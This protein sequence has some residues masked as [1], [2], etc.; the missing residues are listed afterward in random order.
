MISKIVEYS[1]IVAIDT[2]QIHCGES[3]KN[4]HKIDEIT[5]TI[6]LDQEEYELFGIIEH[7]TSPQ[8]F[9]PHIKRK[10]NKWLTYDDIVGRQ[11][12]CS[13][14]NPIAIQMIFYKKKNIGTQINIKHFFEFFIHYLTK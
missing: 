7:Q 10:S 3:E 9:V 14:E 11:F 1:P 2:E 12:E 6:R 4:L 8:H 5:K 13:V